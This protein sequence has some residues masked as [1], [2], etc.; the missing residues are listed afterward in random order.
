VLAELRCRTLVGSDGAAVSGRG[1]IDRARDMIVAFQTG[2][3]HRANVD[4]RT[5]VIER[6]VA[7]HPRREAVLEEFR[8]TT[9]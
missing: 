5:K 9:G 3:A 2:P 6:Y 1:V 4:L 8:R 7:G